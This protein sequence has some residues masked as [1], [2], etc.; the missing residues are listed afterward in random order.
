MCGVHAGV[1]QTVVKSPEPYTY[2]T[3]ADIPDNYDVRNISGRN[4][5]GINRNQHIPHYCGS[6]WAMAGASALSDRFKV[7]RH[8]AF[9]DIDLAPQV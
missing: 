7:A 9:P 1:P 3:D 5:A 2:M 4:F 8:G 6:C